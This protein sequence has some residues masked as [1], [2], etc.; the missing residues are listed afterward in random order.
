MDDNGGKSTVFGK[1][2]VLVQRVL[3][4][5]VFDDLQFRFVLRPAFQQIFNNQLFSFTPRIACINKAVDIIDIR[6][7]VFQVLMQGLKLFQNGLIKNIRRMD[8]Y[9]YSFV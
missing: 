4:C 9:H 2:H 3:A 6:Y 1:E 7:F 8:S 5:S